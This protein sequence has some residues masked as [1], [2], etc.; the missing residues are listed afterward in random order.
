MSTE[1]S[2]RTGYANP[3]LVCEIKPHRFFKNRMREFSTSHSL[4]NG[5]SRTGFSW[6]GFHGLK[7]N[8]FQ[9]RRLL[10]LKMHRSSNPAAVY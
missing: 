1:T 3:N 5:K 7:L 8:R 9:R 4:G 10:K 2:A 6:L